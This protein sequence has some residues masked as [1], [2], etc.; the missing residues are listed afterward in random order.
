VRPVLLVAAVF[1]GA[2]GLVL[3]GCGTG[4]YTAEG[5]QGAGRDLFIQR[6][7]GCHTLAEA[8]TNGRIGPD[9][10]DAFAQA[11]EAGMTS[12]TFTQVVASQIR[13]P[14]ETP[15]TGAPGMPG[16]DGTD[17]TLPK[18]DDVEGDAFCV[19]DQDQ[20]IDDIAV[21]VGAV[22]GTGVVTEQPTDGKS[23]FSAN[24]GSCHTLADA[25]TTGTVGP[26]LDQSQP[27]KDLVVDRVTNGQGAMPSFKD[28]LDAQQIEA[29]ADYVSTAAGG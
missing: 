27:A 16:P 14:I 28:S 15:V 29:V 17:G 6:C 4:G 25:G 9:L 19:E 18:C 12:E 2:L 24:C 7:G 20:A 22:A 10:D 5:S 3:S 23:I 11:R 1:V 8:G 26:N 21:Y 13:F